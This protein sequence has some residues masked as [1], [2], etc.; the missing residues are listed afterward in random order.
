[1]GRGHGAHAALQWQSGWRAVRMP[2][3]RMLTRP[4]SWRGHDSTLDVDVAV[5]P[6]WAWGDLGRPIICAIN[7]RESYVSEAALEVCIGECQNFYFQY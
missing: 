7:R 2:L 6:E 5:D 1:M 4:P 3:P